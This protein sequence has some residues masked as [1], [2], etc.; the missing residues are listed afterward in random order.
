MK[1]RA[2]HLGEEGCLMAVKTTG[3]DTAKHVFQVHGSG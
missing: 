3:L 2:D 1:R